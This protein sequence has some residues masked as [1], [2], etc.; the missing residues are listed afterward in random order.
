[1]IH[2]IYQV[3][4]FLKL[5]KELKKVSAVVIMTAADNFFNSLM[6]KCSHSGLNLCTEF[7]SD[8]ALTAVNLFC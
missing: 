1:M 7:S 4:I 3:L 5:K 6:V 8:N 2:M